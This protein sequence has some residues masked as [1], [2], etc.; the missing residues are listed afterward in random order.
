MTRERGYQA[1]G[2][3]RQAGEA[4]GEMVKAAGHRVGMCNNN[5]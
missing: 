2:A 1:G 3:A 4:G 5:C